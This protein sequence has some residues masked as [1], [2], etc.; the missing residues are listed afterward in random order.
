M[1]FR[2]KE[3]EVNFGHADVSKHLSFDLIYF[4]VFIVEVV[5]FERY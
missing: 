4:L 2:S 1:L 3:I 5:L